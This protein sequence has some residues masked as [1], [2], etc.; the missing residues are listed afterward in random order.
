[1]PVTPL[2]A[3]G[4]E[5][6]PQ[7]V[8]AASRIIQDNVVRL[9]DS[10]PNER[11]WAAYQLGK[12]GDT[13]RA[14]IPPL[15]TLLQDNTPVLLS[16]YLGGG[17]HS[18]NAS[19]PGEEACQALVKIGHDAVPALQQAIRDDQAMVRQLA[20]K[21]LGQIGEL[22]SIVVLLPLLD[23]PDRQ[24]RALTALALGG[25]R[26]PQAAQIIVD[27][28]PTATPGMRIGM[29]YALGQINNVLV[30]PMLIQRYPQEQAD[31]RAAIMYALGQL[32][33]GEA[34]ET[35]LQGLHDT[36]EV[37]RANA[38]NALANY[39]NPRTM[40]ALIGSLDDPAA[41]VRDAA[42]EAL[43]LVSG[44]QFSHDSSRWRLWWHQQQANI[45]PPA[46]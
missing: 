4:N 42:L 24:V 40:D 35:L 19:T 23:D 33:D 41:R 8:A 6:S 32:R 31:V 9:T 43:Q 11:A 15:I 17:Y 45:P 39:Y 38:A 20:A 5:Q 18:S 21:A 1:M 16:R 14:A 27:A 36:D 44:M 25:Y 3:S 28:F 10:D 22:N 2:P 37:V 7:P 46:P 26:H 29:V 13:A 34:I 12:F 30:V